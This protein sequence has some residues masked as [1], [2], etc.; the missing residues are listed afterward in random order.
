MAGLDGRH[1]A[2]VGDA[3][4]AFKVT[5]IPRESGVSS[6]PQPID[7]IADASGI[8][9]HPPEPVIGLAESETRWRVMTV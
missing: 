6:T 5:V 2:W 8:L 9:D 1:H 3:P 7:S 4:R